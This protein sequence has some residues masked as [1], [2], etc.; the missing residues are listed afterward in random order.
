MGR[1]PD[2]R[3]GDHTSHR[4]PRRGWSPSIARTIGRDSQRLWIQP[5]PFHGKRKK[6]YA[7]ATLNRATLDLAGVT[8]KA[9]IDGRVLLEGKRLLAHTDLSVAQIAAY[10]G[11]S[12][13]TNFAKFFKRGSGS[14]P[15]EF[16]T[17]IIK[18]R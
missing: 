3:S 18:A 4:F 6:G 10:L 17:S 14:G 7:A 15:R 13:A 5:E 1:Q 9:F 16:R 11:F 12:E 2:S 8:A